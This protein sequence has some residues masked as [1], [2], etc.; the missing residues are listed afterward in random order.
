MLEPRRFREHVEILTRRGDRFVALAESVEHLDDRRAPAD[1]TCALTSMTAPALTRPPPGWRRL[2]GRW[3]VPRGRSRSCCRCPSCPARVQNYS[4]SAACRGVAA[5]AGYPVAVTCAGRDG[6]ALPRAR[7]REHRG[8]RPPGQ[9]CSTDVQRVWLDHT[10]L[11][12]Q[13][14]RGFEHDARGKPRG[15]GQ[16]GP[17]VTWWLP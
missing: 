17:Q 15:H 2:I 6:L 8:A 13:R 16:D 14:Q 10:P 9:R 11:R 5:R 12:S 1:G 4:S 3:L 7:Q